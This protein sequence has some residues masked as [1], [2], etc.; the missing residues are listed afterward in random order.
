MGLFDKIFNS[1]Q[2]Q[3]QFT[4]APQSEQ[5]AWIA[6]IYACIAADG[7]IT[8]SEVS[9]LSRTVFYKSI[10]NEHDIKKYYTNAKS[11]QTIIGSK[12]LIESSVNEIS[13]DNKA[14]LFT[15]T[16]E[17]LLFDG[18]LTNS[19]KAIIEHLANVLNLDPELVSKI[20][21]VTL[22]RNKGNILLE[23]QITL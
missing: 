21:E 12:T 5:E 2:A 15:L 11:A 8:G 18:I 19:D 9:Q 3:T 16:L 7:D 22:I 1:S 17:L 6:I 13:E 14:T 23:R 10:F 20:M 4:Y